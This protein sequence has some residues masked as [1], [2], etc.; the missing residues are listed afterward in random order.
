MKLKNLPSIFPLSQKVPSGITSPMATPIAKSYF[1][2]LN[3]RYLGTKAPKK[4]IVV[5]KGKKIAF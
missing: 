4:G 2:D 1:Y 3:G 5:V